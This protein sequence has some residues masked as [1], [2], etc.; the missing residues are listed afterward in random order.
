[1][2]LPYPEHLWERHERYV[3]NIFLLALIRL[4]DEDS[5]PEDEPTLNERLYMHARNV[6][7]GLSCKQK[8]LSFVKRN[9]E[10][11]PRK[12]S[13]VGEHWT[14]KKPDFQWELINNN[15]TD[16]QKAIKEYTIECKRLRINGNFINEYVVNGI[17]RFLSQEYKYGNGTVSGTMIGYIQKMEH[18]EA[19]ERI[20]GAILKTKEFD[21]PI[22]KF[23][24]DLQEKDSV[25]KGNHTL[26]RKKVN[27][28][29][30]DLR[31]IWIEVTN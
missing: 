27:P 3:F 1:M 4:R 12:M 13:E 28:S 5:L 15:E 31:H 23:T 16:P 30:F 7:L 19:L 24:K 10:I 6:Y 17:I 21:I 2:R 8:P 22:I 11:P 20:N 25:K 26:N 9:S 14:K 29:I 18:K